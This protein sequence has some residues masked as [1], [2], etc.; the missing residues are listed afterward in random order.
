MIDWT[1][2]K[3]LNA[4]PLNNGPFVVMP[5]ADNRGV[6][7]MGV[8]HRLHSL[9]F[10]AGPSTSMRIINEGPGTIPAFSD[11]FLPEQLLAI[12]VSAGV[13][14][15]SLG[16]EPKLIQQ[17][18]TEAG[19]TA[20]RFSPDGNRLAI[21]MSNRKIAVWDWQGKHR[22]IDLPTRGTCSSIDFSSDGRWLANSDYG[23]C[24]TI[25]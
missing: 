21:A 7:A 6:F 1:S 23:P 18:P 25:R 17:I 16:S 20:I 13:S 4:W 8:D 19:A 9:L 22:L 2:R 10:N 11:Y 24:L 15:F 3:L 12:S 5:M 14:I